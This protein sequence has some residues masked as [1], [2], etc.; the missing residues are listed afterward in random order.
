MIMAGRKDWVQA[1]LRC[2][3]CGRVLGRL[4]G[5]LAPNAT[6][7][8]TLAA[9]AAFRPADPALPAIRLAGNERFRCGTCGGGVLIDEVETFSTYPEVSDEDTERRPR[10]GRPPKPWRPNPTSATTWLEDLGIA[11]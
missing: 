4:V 11:G 9:F 8:A 7:G 10:R 6:W 2:L 1:D 3:M 5:P